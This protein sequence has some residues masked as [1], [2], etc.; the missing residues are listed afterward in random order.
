MASNK[1]KIALAPVLAMSLLAGCGG[2]NSGETSF[3]DTSGDTTPITFSF[4]SVDPSPNWNG[5]KDEVGQVLT[6]KTGVTLNGEFAVSGRQDK[7]SLMAASGDYLDIV[8]PKGE[9][10]KLVDAGAMLDLTDLIDQYAPNLKKLY[11]NYMDR[12][13]KVNNKL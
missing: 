3:K 10:S 1:M 8:S 2:G 9:L 5:M 4:F 12:L 7:I 11:G 6:E 13:R